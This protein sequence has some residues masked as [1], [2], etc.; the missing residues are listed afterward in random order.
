MLYD[1][2]N[3]EFFFF[4]LKKTKEHFTVLN[5]SSLELFLLCVCVCVLTLGAEART[6]I[7]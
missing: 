7:Q 4:L 6:Y 2:I 1:K 5:I 3:V